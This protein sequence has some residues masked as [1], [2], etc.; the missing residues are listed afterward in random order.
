[1]FATHDSGNDCD[2]QLDATSDNQETG[3]KSGWSIRDIANLT[4]DGG[5]NW[6]NHDRSMRIKIEGTEVPLRK[7]VSLRNLTLSEGRLSPPF[8]RRTH[9]YTA[10]V[11]HEVARITVTPTKDDDDAS[12]EF[13]NTSDADP[14]M[15]GHQVDLNYG[16]NP[17][18]IRVT[19][20]EGL[21]YLTHTVEV[22]L[23]MP[24]A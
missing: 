15:P 11:P 5:T 6:S 23:D 8:D 19:S 22:T 1:M 14:N 16:S 2:L 13:R 3:G 9:E 12:L 20:Q 4:P 17:I 21:G 18:R 10:W 24:A 7:N